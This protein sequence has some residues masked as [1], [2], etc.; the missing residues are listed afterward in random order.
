MQKLYGTTTR[1]ILGIEFT[2]DLMVG[3]VSTI[4]TI[5][6]LVASEIIPKTIGATYWRGWPI[7]FQN[8]ENNGTYSESGQAY[9]GYYSSLQS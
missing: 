4:M 7:F 6:I 1:S 9:F 8:P 2:E 3:V 5:L